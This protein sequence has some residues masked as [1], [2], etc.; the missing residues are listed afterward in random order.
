MSNFILI[1]GK[2]SGNKTQDLL[3]LVK[4]TADTNKRNGGGLKCLVWI[5][6]EETLGDLSYIFAKNVLGLKD[7]PLNDG[8]VILEEYLRARDVVLEYLNYSTDHLKS[9]EPSSLIRDVRIHYVPLHMHY[10]IDNLDAF[11]PT[12]TLLT[13]INKLEAYATAN[14]VEVV[15]TINAD[16]LER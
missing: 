8:G 4:E 6:K 13:N 7:T 11:F 15:A 2:T 16:K 14:A 3:R 12:P 10:F 9:L 5:T 1:T